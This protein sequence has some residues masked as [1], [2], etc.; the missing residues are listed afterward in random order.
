MLKT[1]TFEDIIRVLKTY[2]TERYQLDSLI[3]KLLNYNLTIHI[4]KIET[5]LIDLKTFNQ[6]LKSVLLLKQNFRKIF[7]SHISLTYKNIQELIQMDEKYIEVT[8][9]LEDTKKNDIKV[10]GPYYQ[11]FDT[12]ILA[13]NE[14]ISHLEDFLKRL[15]SDEVY[16]ELI[17]NNLLVDMLNNIPE[18][19][20]IYNDW[21][22]KFRLFS[23]C[24]KGGQ[25]SFQ[26]NSIVNNV[27]ALQ[28][29]INHIDEIDQM[30]YVIDSIN[31]L[32]DYK[33]IS[34]IEHIKDSKL[35][36]NISE[37]YLYSVLLNFKEELLNKKPILS[38]ID[39]LE[40]QFNAYKL[41][42]EN[43]CQQNLI[44]LHQQSLT[45]EGKIKTKNI[46]FNNYEKLLDETNKFTQIFIADLNVFNSNL[47]LN[48][49][50]LVLLDDVHLA[51][52]NQYNRINETKQSICHRWI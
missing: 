32:E 28:Q 13:I 17:E 46:V 22:H 47:D 2:K 31:E 40:E 34:L 8:K 24:F 6:Y 21:F 49:F 51:N 16:D 37:K 29:F 23:I 20:K 14:T 44:K 9:K 3:T 11:G 35:I 4:D 39:H 41:N 45:K 1:I 25:S 43:Y 33:L 42:E 12:N 38:T 7:K 19:E 30:V 5:T 50:D 26:D 27:K 52:S 10:L 48:R 15:L 36:I 18:L